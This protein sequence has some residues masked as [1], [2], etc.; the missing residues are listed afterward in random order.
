MFHLEET[1]FHHQIKTMVRENMLEHYS[2]KTKYVQKPR[3]KSKARPAGKR[4]YDCMV[5]ANRKGITKD[6]WWKYMTHN[7][8]FF[9]ENKC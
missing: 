6:F 4:C 7:F 8:K 2:G 5:W 1:V 3:A 9:S